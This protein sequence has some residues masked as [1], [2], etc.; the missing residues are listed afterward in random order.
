MFHGVRLSLLTQFN[1]LAVAF[2]LLVSTLTAAAQMSAPQVKEIEQQ[3]Q[4]LSFDAARLQ[5][6]WDYDGA[7]SL[8]GQG[9]ALAERNF[10][11]DD[12]LTGMCL[13]YLGQNY[14]N[15]GEYREAEKVLLR[16]VKIFEKGGYPGRAGL[17]QATHDLAMVYDYQA[18]YSRAQP[19]YEQAL[20]LD[21]QVFG[22]DSAEVARTL[23]NLASLYREKADLARAEPMLE[24]SLAIR[25]KLFGPD[26]PLIGVMLNNLGGVYESQGN[27]TKAAE[28]FKQAIVIAEKRTDPDNLETAQYVNNLGVLLRADDPRRARPLIERG[29]AIREKILGPDDAEVANSLN[30]LA[31]LDAQ[32]GNL[33]LAEQRLLR[34]LASLQTAYGPAHPLVARVL[35]NLAFLYLARG[36]VKRAIS[37][38]TSNSDIGE[39]N[40]ELALAAG[41]EE[42]KRLYM[43]TT[44]DGTSANISL[45]LRLAPDDPNAA[46]LA[47]TKILR[48][49]GRVLDVMSGQIAAVS[50]SDIVGQAMLSKLSSLRTQLSSLVLKGADN[51]D[52]GQYKARVSRLQEQVRSLETTVSERAAAGG[53]S[54]GAVTIEQVQAAIPADAAL[55]EM[56]QYRPMTVTAAALP[57]W[58]APHYAAYILR[59]TGVPR[60]VDLG[61]AAKIDVDAAH[62]RAALRNPRRADF[63]TPARIVDEEVMRPI[64]NLLGDTRQILLSP[65]G[66]LNLVPFAALVDEQEHLLIENYAFSYVTSGRDLLRWREHL[67]AREGPVVIADPLFAH[68]VPGNGQAPQKGSASTGQNLRSADFTGKFAA[69]E[70]TA[71]EARQLSTLMKGARTFVGDEATEASL[72]RLHGPSILHI[73]THGFF[74]TKPTNVNGPASG[75]ATRGSY[76]SGGAASENPLLRSGLALTGANE[77]DDGQGEDGILTALEATGLDLQGTRLVVLSACETGVGEVQNGEGVYGL[78]RALVLA[79]AESQIMSLWKVDDDATRQLMVDLYKQLQAGASRSTALRQ[80]QLRLLQTAEYRHPFFWA[81]FILSGDW[82]AI[83]PSQGQ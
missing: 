18:D 27:N 12:P 66:A 64:R 47:L 34:A 33:K 39:R 82:R 53:I 1:C 46:R 62:L 69:L 20:A 57:R 23:N 52:L 11:P 44:A 5:A 50:K 76:E 49:K 45:H 73:A 55:V 58:E 17:A 81:G 71:T 48:R 63:S 40:L 15:K 83:E 38:L 19:L 43:A 51:E 72:K 28:F 13:N 80:V 16:A 59:R 24:R 8:F 65:D 10:G 7:I 67:P 32:E 26:H 36:E 41:G 79:G 2:V 4:K 22:P 25:R 37:L 60:F 75:S 3:I 9:L 70:G 6:K 56:V 35:T 42:Q 68:G 29:L 31:L 21:E 74:L 78:R 54:S 77:L 14:T 61:A 30:N